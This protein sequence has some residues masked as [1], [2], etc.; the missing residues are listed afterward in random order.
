[1]YFAEAGAKVEAFVWAQEQ[2]TAVARLSEE[3][4][5]DQL[6]CLAIRW[7]L[8]CVVF[9]I[10]CCCQCRELG[11]RIGGAGAGKERKGRESLGLQ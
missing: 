11:D 1:M 2:V 3:L 4:R 9:G 8:R 7:S 6:A 10:H 5:Q